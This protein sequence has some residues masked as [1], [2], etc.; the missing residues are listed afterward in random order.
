MRVN[1]HKLPVFAEY[2]DIPYLVYED[3]ELGVRAINYVASQT[4]LLPE[5]LFEGEEITKERFVELAE[6]KVNNAEGRMKYK[7]VISLRLMPN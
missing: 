1:I 7:E 3:D 6:K 5:I 2:D 4:G